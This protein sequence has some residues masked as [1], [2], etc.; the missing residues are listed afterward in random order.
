M[1][2]FPRPSKIVKEK[3]GAAKV[4]VIVTLYNYAKHVEECL[5]SIAAQTQSGIELIVVDDCSTD[6]GLDVVLAWLARY[7]DS[8]AT[9]ASALLMT[10]VPSKRKSKLNS[11]GGILLN[12]SA[13]PEVPGACDSQNSILYL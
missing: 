8:P 9:L 13:T 5:D 10:P 3:K 4:A 11:C 6:D 12:L 2:L 7:R 1:N